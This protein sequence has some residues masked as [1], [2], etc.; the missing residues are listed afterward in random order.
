MEW[1]V[2][3]GMQEETQYSIDYVEKEQIDF[4]REQ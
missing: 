2:K 3:G 4:G 1:K